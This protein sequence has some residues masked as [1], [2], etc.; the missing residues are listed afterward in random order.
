MILNKLWIRLALVFGLVTI[1][2]IIIAAALANY[3]VS[4]QFRRFVVH[5]QMNF[6]LA[7]V[8]VDY[9]AGSGSWA[10]V[11]T[12]FDGRPRPGGMGHGRGP[13]FGVSRFVLA[14]GQGRAL[15]AEG[16][17]PP[18]FQ[19]SPQEIAEA[20]PLNWQGQVIGYLLPGGP[21]P[22]QL[23]GPAGAFL[24]QINR[25]LLQAGL[26]A[27][28]FGLL[29]GLL[30]ARGLSAPL[31]RLAEA[32][33]RISQGV[34]DQAVPVSGPAEVAEVARAFNEMSAHLQQAETL[35][36]NLVADV[37]HELRTPLSV[38]QGNLQAILDD[39]YPLDKAEVAAI[40]DETLMLHRLINDLREL[41]QAEAGQ[42]SLNIQLLDLSDLIQ[43]MAAR[44]EE[45]GRAKGLTFEA[46]CPAD[47]PP[48]SADSDRV[49]QVLY[50]LLNNAWQHTP[51]GGQIRL[52]VEP[53]A[54]EVR[55]SVSDSGNGIAAEHL[56]HVFDRFWRADKSR[57]REQGG[58]G[59]GL[60]IA[61]QL[62]E[63]QGGRIG[64][65]SAGVPGQGSRFWFT[66][67]IS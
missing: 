27:G 22:A 59:L 28:G 63:A 23:S 10:G 38:I 49:R 61:R 60:A 6:A 65:E 13:G 36:H 31:S 37:A 46:S 4:A 64:V 3:Q 25:S 34:L 8:L 1:T 48:V 56:P 67:P 45:L 21:G 51:E 54:R 33:R 19:L 9:Y 42:L 41:A 50:N 15:Y 40:Y 30:V 12:I 57:A 35:R 66:V 16:E 20:I 44:F 55:V 5:D 2:V 39:V 11:E 17:P 58:S 26:L 24:G 53:E 43:E 32:A 14:D 18:P 52:E 47:L 7:P 29:M 62:V